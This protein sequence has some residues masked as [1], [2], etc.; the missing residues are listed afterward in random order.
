MEIKGFETR[1]I[2]GIAVDLCVDDLNFKGVS[3]SKDIPKFGGIS[4]H[5]VLHQELI[6]GETTST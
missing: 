4:L 3:I 1:S 6:F 2:E 5:H